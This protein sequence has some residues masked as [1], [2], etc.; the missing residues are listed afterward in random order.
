VVFS[1]IVSASL[2]VRFFTGQWPGLPV[3]FVS[4]CSI[5]ASGLV[6]DCESA[7]AWRGGTLDLDV[8]AKG[9]GST[10][11][12]PARTK[13][14]RLR[15]CPSDWRTGNVISF[16]LHNNVATAAVISFC[17][18][19]DDPG[20]WRALDHWRAQISLDFTG[21]RHVVLPK[22]TLARVNEPVGWDQVTGVYLTG[23]YSPVEIDGRQVVQVD[24]LRL[25][26]V[27]GPLL[28]DENLF[29]LLD[30]GFAGLGKIIQVW[31]DGDR[32]KAKQLL[33]AHLRRHNRVSW[34]VDD[35]RNGERLGVDIRRAQRVCEGV[36]KVVGV[37]HAFPDGRIDWF[38]NPTR[39]RPARA[40]TGEWQT[41]LNRME[42]W[43]ALGRSYQATGEE[44]YAQAFVRQLRSWT[45]QCLH[46][47]GRQNFNN[48][49]W[50]T[51]DA[52]IRMAHTWPAAFHCFRGSPSVSDEDIIVLLKSC[53]E[54]GQYLRRYHMKGNW[55]ATEMAGLYTVGA[56]F[57]ELI[58]AEEWR[59]FAI[60]ELYRQQT[61]QFLSDGAQYELSPG[62]HWVALRDLLS[63]YTRAACTGRLAEL[64][65]DFAR[66]MEA[67]AEY[68][69]YLALPDGNLPKLNDSWDLSVPKLMRR[70]APF[71]PERRDFKWMATCGTEGEAPRELSRAY[72]SA[73]YFVMRSDWGKNANVLIFD[74][75]PP[76]FAHVHQDKLNVVLAAYGREILYDSGGGPYEDSPWRRYAQSSLAHNTINVDGQSQWRRRS[77]PGKRIK[78]RWESTPRYDLAVADYDEAFGETGNLSATCVRQVVFVKPNVFVVHDVLVPKDG[79]CHT[80]ELRWH[81][82]SV[83][84]HV[85]KGDKA[86]FTEDEGVPNLGIVPVLRD[87]LAVHV[88]SGQRKPEIMGWAVEKAGRRR[89]TTIRHGKQA[90]GVVHFLTL[91]V[92]LKAGIAR[93]AIR[94]SGTASE[95]EV[96]LG[97]DHTDLKLVIQQDGTLAVY[98][99]EASQFD[100]VVRAVG[101]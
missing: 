89:T 55:L 57:P 14:L 31:Q 64:P 62:Y 60:T 53:V 98:S 81:V 47:Y 96:A 93:P 25:L 34:I 29:D 88:S 61:V 67:A 50:R 49:A 41:Q 8:F 69:M 15:R 92:P 78:A 95:F 100:L 85:V 38:V 5:P 54:H 82:D 97:Q 91:L 72:R 20:T 65:E 40:Y 23:I 75:G 66:N 2:F 77:I 80:Y 56:L 46:P 9:S 90:D 26:N 32:T 73:G 63:V 94:I 52:G 70:L 19:S 4:S 33:A 35:L 87:G 101:L 37:E 1:L 68:L 16:R 84:T 21:W 10:R 11:W 76:G 79:N 59:R 58:A 39:N 42:F 99:R 28:T 45:S 30:P 17:V 12:L 6:T 22:R 18:A 36:I 86:L 27:E 43:G 13:K 83:D 71:Y 3:V 24:D 7:G 74:G 51:L 48:S 44:V